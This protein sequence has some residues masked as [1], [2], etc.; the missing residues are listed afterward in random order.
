MTVESRPGVPTYSA[1]MPPVSTFC[2]WM[3]SVLRFEP[4]VPVTGSVTL[5][6]LK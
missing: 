1:G 4:N 6:P 2:S 5:M 3:I